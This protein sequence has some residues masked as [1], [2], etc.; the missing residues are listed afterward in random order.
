[1]VVALSARSDELFT[2][3]LDAAQG[4]AGGDPDRASGDHAATPLLSSELDLALSLRRENVAPVDQPLALICQAQRSGG[5]LLGRLFD[6]HPQLSR[7][8]ARAPHRRPPAAHLAALSP[9]EEPEIWFSRLAEKKLDLLFSKGRRRI[10]LKAPGENVRRELSPLP[11]AARLPAPDLPRR[12]Q[13]PGADHLR[14]QILDSYMTSLFN[15]WLDNQNLRGAEKR[16]VVAFSPRR[17]WG[18]WPR[19]VLRALSGRAAD[20]DPAR[21]AELVHARRRG[22][23]RTPPPR[24]CSRPG[25][26]R[27][28]DARGRGPL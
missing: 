18:E 24:T 28:R 19:Q 9:G 26:A 11:A 17:A 14:R 21:P 3:I 4:R 1:M 23:T 5:T 27:R 8:S 10:P 22:A 20:L 6:G 16:W 2:S 12:G 15:G 13:A 25:S 7:P